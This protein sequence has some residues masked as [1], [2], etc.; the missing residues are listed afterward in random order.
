M[1]RRRVRWVAAVPWVAA[2]LVLAA[3]TSA[4][5]ATPTPV[6]TPTPVADATTPPT[7]VPPGGIDPDTRFTPLTVATMTTP[8]PVTGTDG[9]VHLGYEL[10]LTNATGVPVRL[11]KLEVLD[12]DSKKVL[13][14]LSGAPLAADSNLI[15][16]PTGDEGT[17]DP[18]A[19]A[20]PIPSS[21]TAVV[22]LDVAFD[23]APPAALVHH[24]VSVIS[25]PGGAPTSTVDYTVDRIPVAQNPAVVLGPPLQGDGEWYASDGCCAD[26]TH[27][28]RGL[29]PLNGRLL[30]AQRFAVDWYLLDDQHRTRVGDPSKLT[31]YLSYDKPAIAAADG[32]VVDALDG[33]P[34]TTA[35]PKPPKIPPI[36]ETVGNHVT[37]MVAPGVYLL[38]AHFKT[39]TVAVQRGQ[40]VKRGD[41][42]GHIGSS[43]NSTTPHLHFQVMTT[44]TFFPT[45][46]PPYA[47]DCFQMVGQVTER[48]WDDVLGTYP[49]EVLP[50]VAAPNPGKRTDQMPLDRNT[51]RF[52]CG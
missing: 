32:V 34:E 43:G 10:L 20:A 31:S 19:P 28:R 41:V 21:A 49:S 39:G 30:V 5:V 44:G 45:D 38:Y 3:C 12:A 18:T 6:T 52:T 29:A 9:K 50:Y 2:G 15:G 46:S 22:W 4:P 40:Q 42:L 8:A 25:P 13:S 24:I 11:D 35:L 48:V 26:D 1:T 51:V 37:V 23:G 33:L 47:F 27:H 36:T 17:T 14:S 16:G 7:E